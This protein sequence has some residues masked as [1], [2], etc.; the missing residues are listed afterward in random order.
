MVAGTAGEGQ[1][2]NTA[3]ERCPGV[4]VGSNRE[5]KDKYVLKCVVH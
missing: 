1:C 4:G 5:G 3:R 2:G